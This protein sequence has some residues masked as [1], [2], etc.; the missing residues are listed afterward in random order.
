[1]YHDMIIK[2]IIIL[3]AKMQPI[4]R[5]AIWVD[6]GMQ[7]ELQDFIFNAILSFIFQN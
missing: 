2:I 7:R 1:M 6:W 3:R 4:M 5:G